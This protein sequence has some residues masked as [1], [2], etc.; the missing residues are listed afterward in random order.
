MLKTMKNKR[1]TALGGLGIALFL[2][3][4]MALMPFAG[5]VE[6]TSD[7]NTNLVE[8]N[9][10][11]TDD[12][13]TLPDQYRPVAYDAFDPAQ[14]L[15]GMRSL[16]S[17]AY[18]DDEGQTHLITT[19]DPMHY[20][21]DGVW[22][23]IDL[24]IVSTADGWEVKKNLI[25]VEFTDDSNLGV[26]VDIP[27]DNIDA[28]VTG[29]NPKVTMIDETGKE[30][31]DYKFAEAE[32]STSIGGNTLRYHLL[33]G[34]DLDY[35]VG[36]SVVK[37]DLIIRER[38][39]PE[40]IGDAAWFGL[41]EEMILPLGYAL[42]LGEDMIGF[43]QLV[44]T[45]SELSIRNIQTGEELAS[46][47][48]PV[49]TQAQI[50][51][52]NPDEPVLTQE[53]YIATYFVRYVDGVLVISTMVEVDWLLADE[54]VFPISI[55]PSLTTSTSIHGYCRIT[56][57]YC[58]KRNQYSSY[59]LWRFGSYSSYRYAPFISLD[60]PTLP[61]AAT[62]SQISL[63]VKAAYAYYG[64]SWSNKP[65]DFV[66]MQ[67]CGTSQATPG[68]SPT[69]STT[70]LV[71]PFWGS[72]SYT[73]AC[74]SSTYKCSRSAYGSDTVMSHNWLNLG[75]SGT[76]V[77]GD[78]CS[79]TTTCASGVG[80]ALQ[81]AYLAGDR[82]GA[83][84]HIDYT[85]NGNNNMG[86]R[87]AY[88]GNYV[89]PSLTVV[90]T[91]GADL[92]QP[93]M[94]SAAYDGVT[95]YV[96]G[97]RTMFATFIDDTGIDTTS[98]NGPT[99]HYSVDGG[100]T[101]ETP[102]E[103]DIIGTCSTQGCK[104][105]AKTIVLSAGD[106]V[107]YY[108]STAD[109]NSPTANTGNTPTYTFSVE[110][111]ANAPANDRK[112]KILT[113]GV[114]SNDGS[115]HSTFYDRQLTYWEGANEY[116]H[117]WDT[118]D[119]GT[120]SSACFDTAGGGSG[121][122]SNPQWRMMWQNN[123]NAAPTYNWASTA[124]EIRYHTADGGYLAIDSTHGP[125]MNL[126]HW[127]NATDSSWVMTGIGDGTTDIDSPIGS[128]TS[129]PIEQTVW[130]TMSHLVPVPS[131]FTQAKFGVFDVEQ[132]GTT[133]QT[134]TANWI[135]VNSHGWT[136]FFRSTS[137]SPNCEAGY[138][139]TT[140]KW[141]G[142]SFGMR[143][144][145]D[146]SSTYGTSY[147]ESKIKPE[148]DTFKP[149]VGHAPMADSHSK[150][151]T[152]SFT[153]T[154][155]GNP[156]TGLDIGASAG[157]QPTL[158]YEISAAGSSATGTWTEILLTPEGG[159]ANDCVL[160]PCDWTYT[161]DDVERGSTVT[162]KASARDTSVVGGTSGS[163]ANVNITNT[164]SFEV[165][166]PNMVF[167][168]EWHDM[169]VTR[170][171]SCSF[172]ALFYDVTNEI[173]FHYSDDCDGYLS[174]GNPYAYYNKAISG[175]QDQTR[176][177]GATM[178]DSTTAWDGGNPHTN[179]FRIS[180]GASGANAW[181]T[182][183]RGMDELVDYE[184][185]LTGT[186]NGAPSSFYCTYQY[187]WNQA[188]NKNG[189]N[190]NMD[191]P[192]NF[193]FNYFGTEYN[194][195]NN[196][197]RVHIARLGNMYF[198]DDASSA[199]ELSFQYNWYS[200]MIS[201]PNSGSSYSKA[202]NIAPYW[203]RYVSNYCYDDATN[204]CS[205]RTRLL[206]FEG[207]G[208]DVTETQWS[209]Q[210]YTL[211]DSPVRINPAY[212]DYLS[213]QDGI[214]IE[215]GV[216]LQVA[217]G[218]GISVDGT[219]GQV[220]IVGNDTDHITIEGENGN[221]W[222]G[223]AFTGHCAAGTDDRH[224]LSYVD[225]KN[226]S[227]A[228]ISGGSRHGN[229]A[230]GQP[231]S[232][233]N[234]GNFSMD[235]ITFDNVAKAYSHGSGDG[236]VIVMS[237]Y[238]IS[239]A[240]D[241]CLDFAQDSVVTLSEG[242]MNNCNTNGNSWGGAIVIDGTSTKGELT[243]ENLSVTNSY[244]NLIDVEFAAVW[245]QNVSATL[246]GGQSGYAV[247]SAG[248]G[249][250]GDAAWCGLYG[251]CTFVN[252]LTV[253]G[254]TYLSGLS[255]SS[256][257]SYHLEDVSLEGG[258]VLYDYAGI[259]AVPTKYN[260]LMNDITAGDIRIE[261]G[262]VP[263][264]MSTISAGNIVFTGDASSTNT[265][266]GTDWSATGEIRIDGAC[267][268]NIE[269]STFTARR[270]AFSCSSANNK[271]RVTV[272]DGDI[273]HTVPDSF[274][275]NVFYARNTVLTVGETDVS[276]AYVGGSHW[277]VTNVV[278]YTSSNADIR[279]IAVNLNGSPCTAPSD[280]PI[281]L[282]SSADIWF[283]DLATVI[284]TKESPVGSGTYITKANHFV[285]GQYADA[286]GAE[287]FAIGLT[288]SNATGVADN[289]WVITGD[290]D[291]NALSLNSIHVWGAGGVNDTLPIDGWYPGCADANVDDICDDIA[292]ASFGAGDTLTVR[293]E[294]QPVTLSGTPM[295][296][297]DIGSHEVAGLTGDG[298]DST[299][300]DAGETFTF[301]ARV[302]METDVT[303]DG[304][305]IIIKNK[306]K[307]A[308]SSAGVPT[309]TIGPSSTFTATNL[310][311]VKGNLMSATTLYPGLVVVQ[312]NLV[313][314]N[315]KMSNIGYGSSGAAI[316]LGDGASMIVK[317]GS[318]IIGAT[319]SGPSNIIIQVG[320]DS[321]FDFDSSTITAS[322]GTA[323]KFNEQATQADADVI[324]I[325]GADIAID[326]VNGQ[327]Q[328]TD[329]TLN[330]ND[331][332]ISVVNN[333]PPPPPP[334]LCI[335]GGPGVW[336]GNWR[337]SLSCTV[338]VPAGKTM[339]I[340][341]N[342]YG[343]G[344]ETSVDITKPD[345]TT[346]SFG[347]YYFSSY[348]NYDPL[349]S[350]SDD[351][352]YTIV[353]DD[354]WGD[355]GAKM[356]ASL[357]TAAAGGENPEVC[358]MGGPA[359]NPG[360][361][362]GANA[363]TCEFTLDASRAFDVTLQTYSWA[364]EAYV[365]IELST[366][367]GSTWTTVYDNGPYGWSNYIIYELGSFSAA[368]DYKITL[369]DTYGDGGQKLIATLQPAGTMI[370]TF[371]TGV[372]T[373]ADD[374]GITIGGTN[375]E[376]TVGSIDDVTITSPAGATAF[377]VAGWTNAITVNDLT[378]SGGDYG[379]DTDVASSGDVA[380][381]NVDISGTLHAAVFYENNMDAT[382]T[383]T[384]G[385]NTG[386]AIKFG[387]YTSADVS[388]TGLTL[389]SNGIGLEA[390]GYGD[391]TVIDSAFDNT[392]DVEISGSSNVVFIDGTVATTD[393]AL[394]IDVTGSGMF[395]RARGFD[396]TLTADI[397][398]GVDPA[399]AVEDVN[400]IMLDGDNDVASSAETSAT[401]IAE[402]LF[403]VY[404]KD[405]SGQNDMVL[406][407]YSLAAVAEIEYTATVADFRYVTD[408]ALGLS[409]AAG[410]MKAFELV[411]NIDKRVC[412]TTTLTQEENV[413]DCQNWGFSDYTKTLNQRSVANTGTITE[414][415]YYNG[416]GYLG[417][418]VDW[419]DSAVMLDSYRVIMDDGTDLDMTGADVFVTGGYSYVYYRTQMF[420]ASS[421]YGVSVTLDNTNLVTMATDDIGRLG[422]ELGQYHVVDISIH[423]SVINGVGGIHASTYPPAYS[424]D[425]YPEFSVTDSTLVHF[426]P[427]YEITGS[428]SFYQSDSCLWIGTADAVITGNT[429]IGCPAGV[430]LGNP[431]N[432]YAG[433]NGPDYSRIENNTFTDT[434]GLDVWFTFTADA[435]DV[436]V[437]N[438]NFLGTK[439][440]LYGVYAQSAR[441]TG[442]I[443]D[444]NNF[445]SAKEPIY[446]RGSTG[447]EI[448]NNNITG[449]GD[450]SYPGIYELNGYGAISGNTLIDADGG[451]LIDGVTTPP[452]TKSVY[453]GCALSDFA[454]WWSIK[455]CTLDLDTDDILSVRL[456]TD[457][458]TYYE[459][460]LSIERPDGVTDTWARYSLS[461]NSDYDPLVEYDSSADSALVGQYVIT[462]MDTYGDGGQQVEAYQNLGGGGGGL[463][464]KDNTIS[465]SPGRTAPSAVGIWIENCV[466]SATVN[467][468]NN[469]VNI[470]QNALVTDGCDITDTNSTFTAA[471][472][473]A[474]TVYTVDVNSDNFGPQNL[475]IQEG[476]T[477]RWRAMAYYNNAPH[478]V[479][480]NGTG[481]AQNWGSGGTMNLGSTFVKTFTAAGTEDYHCSVHPTLMTGTVTV[482]ANTGN[483]LASTGINIVGVAD[484]VTLDGT[485]VGG[486]GYGVEVDGGSLHMTGDAVISGDDNAVLANDATITS[487]GANLYAGATGTALLAEGTTTVDLVDLSVSGFRGLDT[488]N[489]F[490]WN[491][492]SS[493]A[494]TT[495]YTTANGKIENMSWAGSTNMIHARDY[496]RILSVAN[497]LIAGQLIVGPNAIIDEGNL[498]N[499]NVT[500]LG[501]AT[502]GDI[503]LVIQSTDGARAEYTSDAYRTGNMY[504]DGDMSDWTGT[505]ELAPFDDA[506]P[507]LMSGTAS[508]GLHITFDNNNIY[509]ALTG[510]D[511]DTAGD[512]Q[513]YFDSRI[514][515]TAQSSTGAADPLAHNLPFEAD[516]S[517]V[518]ADNSDYGTK[519][520][521]PLLGWIS[522]ASC[523]GVDAE[524]GN[525]ANTN[526]E[527]RIPL[528]CLDPDNNEIRI[529]AL[530]QGSSDVTSVHP[531][532]TIVNDGTN[533]ES[534]GESITL[535]SN[536]DDL[537]SGDSMRNHVLIYQS[538]VGSSN[539]TDPKQ[540]DVRVKVSA[541]CAQDWAD[542]LDIDMDVA[543]VWKSVNILR[544]CPE[545]TNLDDSMSVDEDS[546]ANII[547]LGTKAT[548][549]VDDASA[550]VWTVTS[551]VDAS[552]SPA[553]LLSFTQ[554]GQSLEITLNPDQHSESTN[555][556]AYHFEFTVTDSNG[557]SV[558][559]PV[560]YNVADV[561]DKPIIMDPDNAVPVFRSISST[562]AGGVTTNYDNF[563][564]EGN[565]TFWYDLGDSATNGSKNSQ[566]GLNGLIYDM[567]DDGTMA[568]ELNQNW[569]WGVDVEAGC[570]AFTAMVDENGGL[571]VIETVGNEA[572]GYCDIT[573]SLSDGFDDADDVTISIGVVPVNDAPEILSWDASN[574]IAIY[575]GN[576]V[577]NSPNANTGD[578]PWKIELTE[579]DEST[580]NLTFNL[581]AM[582]NDIDHNA[583]DVYWAVEKSTTCDY[584]DFFTIDIAG[585][586]L[587]IDLIKDAT[588]TAAAYEVDYFQD[589]DGDGSPDG[590]IHQSS[591]GFCPIIVNLYDSA[592]APSYYPNYDPATMPPA[593]YQQESASKGLEVRVV[594]V[595]ENVP[596]YY[597]DVAEG[598]D[599]HGVSYIIPKTYVPTTV[600]IGAAGDAGPYNYK[601]MIEVCMITDSFEDGK[602]CDTMDAPAY[603]TTI[604]Y[605]HDLLIDRD[606]TEVIVEMDVLTC[607]DDPCD[608]NKASK[609]RFWS[610]SY[611]Q[612]QSCVNG[613]NLSEK[614]SCPG[615]A[616]TGV[617]YLENGNVSQVPLSN[618]RA[619]MLEDGLWCNNVM[620]SDALPTDCNQQNVIL[621]DSED[622]FLASTSA[623]PVVVNLIESQSVPSFAPSIIVISAAGMFVSALVLSS[624]R[625]DDE[626]E[627]EKTLVD[628]E[629]AVS[630]VIA[631]ILMVAIT[632]V[633]SGVIYVWA[634]SLADTSGGK[635]V[636]RF[637]FDLHS[638]NALNT[639]DAYYGFSVMSSETD[640][641]TQSM[642][643]TV[644]YTNSTGGTSIVS[645]GL[646]ETTVYGFGPTNS[647]S[648][649]TF[650]DSP[651]I[652][653]TPPTSTFNTGDRFYVKTQTEDGYDFSGDGFQ[654]QLSYV[655]G[656]L[657][658]QG[659]V[660][661]VWDL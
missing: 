589:A 423:N 602:E 346:Q 70:N 634:S 6:N 461:S 287:V 31:T 493:T 80:G 322:G 295:T 38:P 512:L 538:Y 246:T 652:D 616:A 547:D 260:A 385:S 98:G 543:N 496:A 649:V 526:T 406:A 487:D 430:M 464:M 26:S 494:T 172:Q 216:V 595:E 503:G 329:Y 253:T 264:T 432:Y 352:V 88:S 427:N 401:G 109:T 105:K 638:D 560:T 227:K 174:G 272:S 249:T 62:I 579:D 400:V 48:E 73:Y 551:N 592:D 267:G 256:A 368:G 115:S 59:T 163:G 481:P 126:L 457:Y 3:V 651:E 640:L 247:N 545:F 259:G 20:L 271:N 14:E 158:Y 196:D 659:S 475:T 575:D 606:T 273:T 521:N 480:S 297:A 491:G 91:A 184:E 132:T 554:T 438:N 340:V 36:E 626:A 255:V 388:F 276:S 610:Y 204:D 286:S 549:A 661:R 530:V 277:G 12:V 305:N 89:S 583:E 608:L 403:N 44:Q 336:Y 252:N 181:E 319:A 599:F 9:N 605:T 337:G 471:G 182:F 17:K 279:L 8:E 391:I 307:I 465:S 519:L 396:Y 514:T 372:I 522:D 24:N 500:H 258:E 110:D 421:P 516:Y 129:S 152:F 134:T 355:G 435:D 581:S 90:Y 125:N 654:V 323:L 146:S 50:I 52:S 411:D 65:V 479:T 93:E 454:G 177:Y 607:V 572:G 366:D 505:Y 419:T 578:A 586:L 239:N 270:M 585:D 335:L 546:A 300:L 609:D 345:G 390:Q 510:V 251:S 563:M 16:N 467:S 211:I 440:S 629:G 205:I 364:Y 358:N 331:V 102:V 206:P 77:T 650:G 168:V 195:S 617:T 84:F 233:A 198:R 330:N 150:S 482:T 314:D 193:Y 470:L 348:T 143:E 23:E 107:E 498:F 518:G 58:G 27:D 357:A 159:N 644:F 203:H 656:G 225:I 517:F 614:W 447:W 103:G 515:G 194:G 185:Q 231:F 171:V 235:H 593:N 288:K 117:E 414:Y 420:T 523:T 576:G 622:K 550:L 553:Q 499:L 349:V 60:L 571:D 434:G 604:E 444:N 326:S 278:A 28:I 197:S 342:Q 484:E 377:L 466:G 137:T 445:T 398:D 248:R 450:A 657:G 87:Q 360:F 120:G 524:M 630:P 534:F 619:P 409:D 601:H 559:K 310:A 313:L 564:T 311:T 597:F 69:C 148:P 169:G 354:T 130:R 263:A 525:A 188:V 138:S 189:C 213:F 21:E 75:S 289:V 41:T 116:L 603:G 489:P 57:G 183:D 477:V 392:V 296:C 308:G 318:S 325:S 532:Q 468:A 167:V 142:F 486:F 451:I 370:A 588:T 243:V 339:D 474:G 442:M 33:D 460:S 642:F 598:F 7:E 509:I 68:S 497:N 641:A 128:G 636:P 570:D 502:T 154:E 334:P 562:D 293:L 591:I 291:G 43:D 394:Q 544:A 645:Y 114:N 350:Y 236:T 628:D 449:T 226:T 393:T 280:C 199:L 53:D 64:G 54:R 285:E 97:A 557:L 101:S 190:V 282:V 209:H 149:S 533:A 51:P 478:D 5:V 383:G 527:I 47:P 74:A 492:G 86:A 542:I 200:S 446:M 415:D 580:S 412:S 301:E 186:S 448:T 104:V 207:K 320:K 439:Q 511:F 269:I 437:R 2:C 507:G 218:K 155:V 367:G 431:Y 165:G 202:G 32:S 35:S 292:T 362:S 363:L 223:I 623:L 473:T 99:L 61:S 274:S 144:D 111:V 229:H 39:N 425:P 215:P 303:L 122:Y 25:E 30:I 569:S 22:E 378:V 596:D 506:A 410:N 456:K 452:P 232:N 119:C 13:F 283:G 112:L 162:Y 565:V 485:N 214:T 217:N 161:L 535:V 443:I 643:V 351:G 40:I 399:V 382:V 85:K 18:L 584:E 646:A 504:A 361:G 635:G 257:T 281:N 141:S 529:L 118:S 121:T 124:N 633:L 508:D 422:W 238:S 637:T 92:S 94:T 459:G 376:A 221:D 577:I 294:P 611:P 42:Y 178:R 156:P 83:A 4:L 11:S 321:S 333:P 574:G 228:A 201:M 147:A 573:L 192:D 344:S 624:R 108:W 66:I 458:W 631:T 476:D 180:T 648:L 407:D 658:D 395:E 600:T 433:A 536:T 416:V 212:G 386:A 375:G 78:V 587:I 655:P 402:L 127:Y 170:T 328:I 210:T 495:L 237:D 615:L 316:D 82:V 620:S 513:I 290:E 268:W 387:Q 55:D 1:A 405:S 191:M 244:V 254:S 19:A 265:L 222:L 380:F 133:Y 632:V 135:C 56:Y 173:E 299:A 463:V 469:N 139:D 309:L 347:P 613:G 558:D 164:Y 552:L 81:T 594:N 241:S 262:S 10:S 540:Y 462:A 561:N 582:K 389:T 224:T 46:L 304:C 404:T 15:K 453:S 49:V 106:D 100:V 566:G 79:T 647:D 369:G 245:L 266:Q 63:K 298:G 379:I 136:Y 72:S 176:T 45:Q 567:F 208:T 639:V 381:T 327:P 131:S 315:G 153:I 95:S 539:P 234:V 343:W 306:W 96:E 418:N 520:Y 140:R 240:A 568:Y 426:E 317:S 365:E 408:S 219:C 37:Q 353:L 653:T 302:T 441:S 483:A 175:Y 284:V 488:D 590:G 230:A 179:N 71:D 472:G 627:L 397:T 490:T 332:G 338:T 34:F 501:A 556:G 436:V 123:P 612:A 76:V 413:I 531:T 29:I 242:T 374:V 324:T 548:D 384:I 455:T 373:G 371:N 417:N 660:L 555:G 424:N 537:D 261:G 220:Q 275:T 625:E 341:V 67:D 541:A 428:T 429:L 160:A 187:Y 113:E 618:M 312:G 145:Q 151:R 356:T 359:W 621:P 250:S 528:S 157:A 166:D